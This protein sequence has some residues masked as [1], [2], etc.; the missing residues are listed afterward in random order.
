MCEYEDNFDK[1]CQD[2]KYIPILTRQYDS[3]QKNHK[4]KARLDKIEN[5][6]SRFRG[7]SSVP[8]YY[9]FLAYAQSNYFPSFKE[10]EVV[11]IYKYVL[12]DNTESSI[13]DFILCLILFAD[14]YRR[15]EKSFSR[16][17]KNPLML[18]TQDAGVIIDLVEKSK[19]LISLLEHN[20]VI[21]DCFINAVD[22]MG[23][24]Y[25]D[26][27]IKSLD[28]LAVKS[29]L[30]RALQTR[31]KSMSYKLLGRLKDLDDGEDYYF[32]ALAHFIDGEYDEALRY[33][34]K[35]QKDNID[36]RS[37][38]ALKLEIY[39]TQG[40]FK[41]F[42]SCVES[43][44]DLHF[45]TW[46]MCYL[47][48]TLFLHLG[49]ETDLQQVLE[50][51]EVFAGLK[52]DLNEESEYKNPLLRMVADVLV[53]GA[54]IFEDMISL[55]EYLSKAALTKMIDR[56]G[57]LQLVASFSNTD[58]YKLLDAEA[59]KEKDDIDTYKENV[60]KSIILLLKSNDNR[61]SM[62][63]F[64]KA[65][66]CQLKLGAVQHFLKNVTSQLDTLIQYGKSGTTE[67]NDILTLAYIEGS[68]SGNLDEKLKIYVESNQ[69]VRELADE[70]NKKKIYHY[71]SDN[72]KRAYAAAEWIY[73]ESTKEDY[74]WR[75]AGML[76]LA[77]YRIIELE[78]NKKI[79]IPLLSSTGYEKL[80]SVFYQRVKELSGE[81]KKNYKSKWSLIL[82]CYSDM[83]QKS[84]SDK[85]MMLGVMYH[86]FKNIGASYDTQDPLA[87]LIRTSLDNVLTS[88]GKEEFDNGYFENL[89]DANTRE[90]YRNPPAH[91]KYLTYE[92][93]CECRKVFEKTILHLA[94]I[95]IPK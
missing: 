19:L 34:G 53:E 17:N 84:F 75:D 93:A 3:L 13:P 66:M 85:F 12:G 63:N 23:T 38:I 67:A 91:T 39:A 94:E 57:I 76:S 44:S 86:L 54:L 62:E 89:V 33:A 4:Y 82:S 60:E 6:L 36:Y 69:N 25:L 56:I 45:E 65:A 28:A 80:N 40:R 31:N 95:T 92:T 27:D 43:N 48:A 41:T 30:I 47:L 20:M 81:E 24:E 61:F 58:I 22:T 73:E 32:E 87:G 1:L 72:G 88:D 9:G 52:V 77:Y 79:I 2:G 68:A 37:T 11:S 15:Q 74:G 71:L 42:S 35:V 7:K 64:Y 59:F 14:L 83:E 26:D 16:L 46:H 18:S 50:Y 55:A 5:D 70:T 90:K 49:E 10:D 29:R 51:S 8:N 21:V 78:L